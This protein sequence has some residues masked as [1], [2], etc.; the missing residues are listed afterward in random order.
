MVLVASP[1]KPFTYNIKG[2][3]RRPTILKEY[4]DDIE[5]VYKEVEQS[6]QSDVAGPIT[7]DFVN[8]QSFL[9]I[10]VSKVLGKPLDDDADLFRNG[11][12]RYSI[13]FVSQQRFP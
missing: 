5:A 6:A 4:H 8:V 9:R 12:D 1:S 2:Y 10:V 3:P 11:C 7:W 13:L